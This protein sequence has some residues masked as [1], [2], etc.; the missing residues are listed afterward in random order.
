[1]YETSYISFTASYF[2]KTI[3]QN[4]KGNN[5]NN[6]IAWLLL[7]GY[8]LTSADKHDNVTSTKAF[9]Q[10]VTSFFFFFEALA[11]MCCPSYCVEWLCMPPLRI[12]RWRTPNG[13]WTLARGQR[14]S[15]CP[16]SLMFSVFL[17]LIKLQH[18][19]GFQ[20]LTAN[21]VHQLWAHYI[22]YEHETIVHLEITRASISQETRN[23]WRIRWNSLANWCN[24]SLANTKREREREREC[25]KISFEVSYG[26]LP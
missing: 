6:G 9:F 22:R 12:S 2:H 5:S 3:T 26:K 20:N 18:S 23:R 14:D 24:T 10:L 21:C 25:A 7:Y 13:L 11:T 16:I 4:A 17:T 15:H 8:I 19:F 1:M